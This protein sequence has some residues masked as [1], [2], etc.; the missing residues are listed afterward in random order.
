MRHQLVEHL[1]V[2]RTACRDLTALVVGTTIEALHHLVDNHIS[3]TRIERID[4]GHIPRRGQHRNVANA[5]DVLQCHILVWRGI[6]HKFAIRHQRSA[7]A[8]CCHV[9][10]A[11]VRNHLHARFVGNNG[12]LANLQRR[13]RKLAIGLGNM[14]HGLSVRGDEIDLLD[15]E[16]TLAAY[17][18]RRIGKEVAEFE[19]ERTEQ[20]DR[21]RCGLH[22]AFNF[23]FERFGDLGCSETDQL[24]LRRHTATFDLHERGIDTI[25]RRSRHNSYG[26]VHSW[27]CFRVIIL[28]SKIVKWSL[29][30]YV[31]AEKITFFEKKAEKF[32]KFRN[33]YYFC[34][35]KQTGCSSAR[36]EY[37]SGG[38]V[39]AG[40][41]PVI[42]TNRKP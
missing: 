40:S 10:R 4:I 15:R 28:F 42:P 12:G 38:R 22:G 3:R 29:K 8:T 16:T 39:V 13:A 33:C 6:E 11:E 20:I 32:W 24:D 17:G 14:P 19:V 36:L 9:H 2:D 37:T 30:I 34:A 26:V 21:A 5:A 27:Y 35:P 7:L 1:G 31:W 41:N 25:E 18:L 23:G